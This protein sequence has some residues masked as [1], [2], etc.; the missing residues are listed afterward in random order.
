LADSDKKLLFQCVIGS[1]L[2][3]PPLEDLHHLI[4]LARLPGER[5]ALVRQ[6][7]A[8][9]L[10]G[11]EKRLAD[12]GAARDRHWPLRLAELYAELARRDPL[13]HAEILARGFDQPEHAR[14]ALAAGFDRQAAAEKLLQHAPPER[15]SAEVIEVLAALPAP[16]VAPQVRKLWGKGLDAA[17]LPILARAHDPSDRAKFVQGLAAPNLD[18][19]RSSLQALEQLPPAGDSAEL[20]A[21]LQALGRLPASKEGD[22]LR[23]DFYRYLEKA[24]GQK[25]GSDRSR[26]IAW[27]SQ[28]HPQQAARL[29]NADGV[30]AA[31]WDKRL[32]RIA[33]AAGNFERGRQVFA[34]AQCASCHSAGQ[35]LGPDLAGVAKRFARADLFTA[36]L[37]PSRDVS[38]RYQM[39]LFETAEGKTFQGLIVYEAVDGV[40]LQ[41]GAATTVRLAG[42]QIASRRSSPVSLMPA[43]LLDP[44][45]DQEIADL[46]AY[47]RGL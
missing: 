27:Y 17:I 30:D 14:F 25:L 19:V 28:A 32:D 29:L 44:L 43:G 16:R 18:T 21:V 33:W 8:E 42:S 37:Q 41:T 47:L 46:Y 20:F 38:P 7:A 2:S 22:H 34:K 35:A 26:W 24:T 1:K 9:L 15:W 11:L 6:G 40:I 4:V 10:L 45:S 5:Y 39:A 23:R 12:S 36:I 13:L 31:A 3:R